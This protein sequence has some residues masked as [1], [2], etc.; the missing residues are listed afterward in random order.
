M[1]TLYIRCIDMCIQCTWVPLLRAV[2]T[3]RQWSRNRCLLSTESRVAGAGQVV[4]A[5]AAGPWPRPTPGL[6]WPCCPMF[7][8]GKK[9]EASELPAPPLRGIAHHQ[10]TRRAAASRAKTKWLEKLLAT[11]ASDLVR[12]LRVRGS[13]S[14]SSARRRA[15]VPV[16]E[17]APFPGFPLLVLFA[18]ELA[19][20]AEP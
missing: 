9:V 11:R 19:R 3:T 1:Y 8:W 12:P 18:S 15:A 14:E 4:E 13:S 7:S 20:Q 17:L 6:K 5:V 16:G 2:E 10:S